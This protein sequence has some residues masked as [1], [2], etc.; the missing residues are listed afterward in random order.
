MEGDFTVG[1]SHS[2]GG[3]SPWPI[4]PLQWG[5]LPVRMAARDGPQIGVMT[6]PW[7]NKIPSE[8]NLSILGVILGTVQPSIPVVPYPMSSNV[9][10]TIFKGELFVFLLHSQAT[11]IK[12]EIKSSI[13]FKFII[14]LIFGLC[15]V[16]FVG[17]GTL[18]FLCHSTSSYILVKYGAV[19]FEHII[20]NIIGIQKIQCFFHALT[21][22]R[23]KNSNNSPFSNP[24][25]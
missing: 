22:S 5:Y 10:I 18:I 14:F 13:M 16:G 21:L 19:K 2:S 12:T 1:A 23:N 6:Y 8:A 3:C 9:R 25:K 15:F 7:V 24:V 11:K 20:K 4:I 17:F